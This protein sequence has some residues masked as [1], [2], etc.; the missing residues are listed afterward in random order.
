MV[1]KKFYRIFL[2]GPMG[3]GKS[4]ALEVFNVMEYP[5]HSDPIMNAANQGL[6][7]FKSEPKQLQ[8]DIEK[9]I[10]DRDSKE[11]M[12]GIYDTSLVMARSFGKVYDCVVDPIP[13]LSIYKDALHVIIDADETTLA[14]NITKRGREYEL[15]NVKYYV[16]KGKEAVNEMIKILETEDLPYMVCDL[17]KIKYDD[18]ISL[19]YEKCNFKEKNNGSNKTKIN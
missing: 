17:S 15:E 5:T 11:Y 14:N 1:M 12:I 6:I 3:V 9:V 19:I 10:L 7:N 8:V 2:I 13:D 16:Q 4:F 18:V